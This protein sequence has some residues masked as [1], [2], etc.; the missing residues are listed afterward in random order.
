MNSK[1]KLLIILLMITIFN[2]FAQEKRIVLN[3]LIDEAIKVS[4]KIQ[5]LEAKLGVASSRIEQGTNLPDPKLTFGLMNMPTNS[6]SFSQEPMTGKVIDISQAI[7]YPAG[8]SA[9]SKVKVVDTLIVRQEIINAKNEIKKN[10]SNIYYDLQ[11]AGQEKKLNDARISLLSQILEVVKTKYEV[12]DASMQNIIKVEIELTRVNEKMEVLNGKENGLL[13]E[14]SVMLQREIS[15][16]NITDN[17]LFRTNDE[18]HYETLINTAMKN[19]PNLKGIKLSEKKA[20]LMEEKAEYEFYPNFNLGVQY[21]QR[22]KNKVT[23]ID[24]KDF[25]S[26]IVGISLPINYGGKKT[27]KVNEAKYLQSLYH[28]KY[29]V[30]IQSLTRSIR[31]IEEKIVELNERNIIIANTLLPLSEQSLRVALSDFQLGKIDFVNVINAEKEILRVKT[32]LIRIQAEYKKNIVM[33]EYFVGADLP[34]DMK[35]NGELR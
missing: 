22:D 30:S 23:R 29:N 10:T 21:S 7:P 34:Q 11:F 25:L 24:F 19:Q 2:S 9:A 13:T 6:F 31:L 4:P 12:G 35:V 27:A 3:E 26:V 16:L 15:Q 18:V 8:L 28:E 14:L 33:L 20:A 32:D 5:M 17:M 1:T